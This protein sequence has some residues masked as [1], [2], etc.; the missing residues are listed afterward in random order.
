M[1]VNQ[2]F[3][4]MEPGADEVE[5]ARVLL[6]RRLAG[7]AL[8]MADERLEQRD[9]V[10]LLVSTLVHCA[11]DGM[12]WFGTDTLWSEYTKAVPRFTPE[13]RIPAVVSYIR[14]QRSALT[15]VDAGDTHDQL[16]ELRTQYLAENSD[17]VVAGARASGVARVHT[18]ESDLL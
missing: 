15:Y 12:V 11:Q 7:A 9:K 4:R 16:A 2:V 3:E 17:S 18:I 1:S 8:E 13:D 5:V 6:A 14:A 10:R